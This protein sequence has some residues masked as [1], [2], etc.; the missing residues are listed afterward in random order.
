MLT[1]N[2]G[3]SKCFSLTQRTKNSGI[4][5][6]LR[7][8]RRG[9]VFF[10]VVGRTYENKGMYFTI[11]WDFYELSQQYPTGAAN[12]FME[13]RQ[14]NCFAKA[15]LA[16]G[17]LYHLNLTLVETSVTCLYSFQQLNKSDPLSSHLHFHWYLQEITFCKNIWLYK[18][19]R[20]NIWLFFN[21]IGFDHSYSVLF[22]W[23]LL[24]L[25]HYCCDKTSQLR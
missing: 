8:F 5:S 21:S 12:T 16:L 17:K 1:V 7:S 3:K 10:M 15:N 25:L 19:S 4:L 6:F 23:Y 20:I 24:P 22:Y 11:G 18:N 9:T 13:K 2:R 14:N